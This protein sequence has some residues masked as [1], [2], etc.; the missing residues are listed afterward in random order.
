MEPNESNKLGV[1]PQYDFF[2][3]TDDWYDDDD[4]I[5]P[6]YMDD[7][8]YDAFNDPF[9]SWDE[10]IEDWYDPMNDF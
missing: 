2:V 10:D 7:P 8:N 1:D 3:P 5:Y 4:D 9:G 6:R